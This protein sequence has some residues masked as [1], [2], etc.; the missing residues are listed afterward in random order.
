MREHSLCGGADLLLRNY[1]LTSESQHLCDSG[2]KVPPSPKDS[3]PFL[4]FLLVPH[5]SL[6]SV[7]LLLS[8]KQSFLSSL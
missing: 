2:G 3:L 1:L 5:S 7:S 6:A 4:S 8:S